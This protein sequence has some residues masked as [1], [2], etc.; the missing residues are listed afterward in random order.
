[1][2]RVLIAETSITQALENTADAL[3]TVNIRNNKKQQEKTL[4][5]DYFLFRP[6][7]ITNCLKNKE[8]GSSV[9]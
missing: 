8:D 1:M 2:V 5:F 3:E 9:C 7:F 6:N 4:N